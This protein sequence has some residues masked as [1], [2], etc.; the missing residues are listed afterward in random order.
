LTEGDAWATF[1]RAARPERTDAAFDVDAAFEAF[2]DIA[3][4]KSHW[5]LGHSRRVADLSAGAAS[6]ISDEVDSQVVRRA[7]LVHD[8]GRVAVPTGVWNK[9][10]TLSTRDWEQVRSHSYQTERILRRAEPMQ[11]LVRAASDHHERSDGSGYH[12]AV[13]A[14]SVA[15]EAR[16][17]AAADVFDA[18]TSDRPHRRALTLEA[19]SQTMRAMPLDQRAVAAVL[20]AAGNP[21]RTRRSAGPA[22]LS[23]REIEVL[24]LLAGGDSQKT[25]AQKLFLS[26]S[27]VHTH[28]AHVYEKVGVSTRAAAALFAMQEGLL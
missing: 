10:G 6:Q 11:P 23:E 9:V 12:R 3:D 26:P 21:P 5:L 1:V 14:S 18:L 27:T 13:D 20:T 25:I 7:G 4:L 2:A 24:R 8:I 17:I 16:L 15:M 22:G 28:V 19:A